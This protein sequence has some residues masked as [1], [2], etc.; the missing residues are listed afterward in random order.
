MEDLIVRYGLIAIFLGSALE[1]EPFALAGGVFAHRQWVS[2][3]AAV[4]ATVGGA[5]LVD[6]FWFHLSRVFRDSRLV[7][8]V[9]R[10][11]AFGRSL[12]MI[13]RH[14]VRFILLFRFAYGLRAVAPVAIGAS[15]VSARVFMALDMVAAML[16][17][18]LF[19]GLGYLLGPALESAAHRYGTALTLAGV[20]LS[21]FVLFL[22][23][24]KAAK[25]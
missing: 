18:G 20:G 8:S 13:E 2:P 24:R 4:L 6:Q 16:W 9:A 19:T 21:L 14:P 3:H 22:V 25:H 12:L 10:R 1:G 7:Q 15:Q 17:G 11:P 5:F 23:I